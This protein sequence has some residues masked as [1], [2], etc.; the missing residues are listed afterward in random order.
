MRWPV[1]AAAAILVGGIATFAIAPPLRMRVMD[2][3]ADA[4]NL[5]SAIAATP[6]SFMT[7]ILDTVA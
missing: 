6:A 3:A 1:P 7:M 2:A 4:P 5:A